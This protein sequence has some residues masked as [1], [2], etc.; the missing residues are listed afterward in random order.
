ML[1]TG[2][3]SFNF[4]QFPYFCFRRARREPLK[5]QEVS[6]TDGRVLPTVEMRLE[7]RLIESARLII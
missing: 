1:T 4:N 2:K 7:L 6:G 5:G 3:R